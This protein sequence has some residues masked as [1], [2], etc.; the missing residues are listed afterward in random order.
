MGGGELASAALARLPSRAS[1]GGNPRGPSLQPGHQAPSLPAT[2]E[3][4][5]DS[6]PLRP[7]PGPAGAVSAYLPLAWC[8]DGPR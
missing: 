8:P 1:G 2:T 6:Q 5:E 3:K 7:W 4:E